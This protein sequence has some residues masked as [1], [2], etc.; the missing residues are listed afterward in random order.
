M[1]FEKYA[2]L[3]HKEEWMMRMRVGHNT[4]SGGIK[5]KGRIVKKEN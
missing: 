1:K 2:L 3:P 5:Y 4:S